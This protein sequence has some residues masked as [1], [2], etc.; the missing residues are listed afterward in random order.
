MKLIGAAVSLQR[1][2]ASSRGLG[3]ILS[4]EMGLGKTVQLLALCCLDKPYVAREG[5]E[6]LLQGR[7]DSQAVEC[8]KDKSYIPTGH[9]CGNADDLCAASGQGAVLNPVDVGSWSTV[10]MADSPLEEPRRQTGQVKEHGQK[11]DAESLGE[12]VDLT[13]EE[14][15]PEQ[16]LEGTV[17]RQGDCGGSAAQSDPP[18]PRALPKAGGWAQPPAQIRPKGS[19]DIN[20][21]SGGTLVIC[22]MSI[23]AQWEDEISAHIRPGHVRV[24][25]HYGGDRTLSPRVLARPD[26]VL[27]TYGVLAAEF[28]RRSA[29]AVAGQCAGGASAALYAIDW[30]RVILD[31]AHYIKGRHT[32]VAQAVF[33]LQ[34]ERRWAVTGTPVQ[35]KLDDLYPLLRFIQL[36][37]WSQLPFWQQHV[38]R[39]FEE[40]KDLAALKLLR[41]ALQPLL[42][43]RTKESRDGSGR[44]ILSLPPRSDEVVEL[45]FSRDEREFYDALYRHSRARFDALV[46]SGKA[47][48]S[49][50][51]ILE[52]LLRLRQCCAHP[53]LMLS[54]CDSRLLASPELARLAARLSSSA[55]PA[56]SGSSC[57]TE[58]IDA[59]GEGGGDGEGG[60]PECAICLESV[61]DGVSTPCAHIFCRECITDALRKSSGTLC[62]SC[63]APV[64][65]SELVSVLPPVSHRDFDAERHWRS[66]K[67]I[68]YLIEQLLAGPEGGGDRV[69]SVVFSQWTGMLDLV[70]LALRRVGLEYARLD[71]SMPQARRMESVEAFGASPRLTVLLVS[72]KAGGVGINLTAASRVFLLD[73]WWNPAVDEQ[74]APHR[75]ACARRAP[76]AE[77]LLSRCIARH[78]RQKQCAHPL[79]RPMARRISFQDT[80]S[81]LRPACPL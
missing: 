45:D 66:S 60:A 40:H 17:I 13:C 6:R 35:N 24:T 81:G 52:M 4:D 79:H 29:N 28:A 30:H 20:R 16:Q 56:I 21:L 32:Q 53:Y 68:D 63:R 3:G 7:C 12:I 18:P 69:K 38:V 8:L 65:R 47:M 37:P 61:D 57:V 15:A 80:K 43:R 22:P 51:S 33:A 49:Y 75:H 70:E 76:R 54:R 73:M 27:T 39:P 44:L 41:S 1:P 14:P 71:G 19:D 67:K 26:I 2:S 62:P 72:L 55:A 36:E 5:A 58:P 31:E 42:L 64:S 11:R 78:A 10:A 48:H 25:V 46:A 23:L 50:A 77:G 74:V 59:N 34:G 9:S